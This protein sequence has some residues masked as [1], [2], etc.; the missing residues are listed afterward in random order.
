VINDIKARERLVNTYPF[1]KRINFFSYFKKVIA[2]LVITSTLV[3]A[4][5]NPTAY[6]VNPKPDQTEE[7]QEVPESQQEGYM[8]IIDDLRWDNMRTPKDWES[9]FPGC[10]DMK[11]RNNYANYTYIYGRERS[12]KCRMDVG[13]VS[14]Y[15]TF[16][17]MIYEGNQWRTSRVNFEIP[18]E[19][20]RRAFNAS[21]SKKYA[22]AGNNF[23]SKYTCFLNILHNE[24]GYAC[25][26]GEI[27]PTARTTSILDNLQIDS[28]KF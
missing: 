7:N 15:F 3:G 8:R 5:S 24:S 9:R 26:E 28:A 13:G 11:P 22:P 23:C 1:A 2:P 17:E 18:R 10:M 25:C 19:D 16:A 27:R 4:C 20:Q 12:D 14:F 6:Q 21:I